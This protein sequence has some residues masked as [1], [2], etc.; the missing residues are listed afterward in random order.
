LLCLE[1]KKKNMYPKNHFAPRSQAS[2][3]A[4]DMRTRKGCPLRARAIVL[5]LIFGFVENTNFPSLSQQALQSPPPRR[6]FWTS[7][8][9]D[10]TRCDIATTLVGGLGQTL[11]NGGHK[12]GRSIY[13]E[14]LQG[15][16]VPSRALAPLIDAKQS[17]SD[18]ISESDVASFFE[19]YKTD[20]D[21]ARTDAF[22][23]AFPLS[24]CE[25]FLPFN[26]T[27]IYL[28]AHRYVLGR[29]HS[30]AQW[31]RLNK[32]LI[33]AAEFGHVVAAM[34]R[35]DAEYINYF[36]GLN[37]VVLSTNSFW[38]AGPPFT[39]FT[40]ERAEILVGPLQRHSVP[41][42]PNSSALLKADSL[43]RRHGSSTAVLSRCKSWRTTA[44]PSCFHMQS[45][46]TVLL[47]C[48]RLESQCLFRQ[49]SS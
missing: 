25:A 31:L 1:E 34:G 36:T 17:H 3:G 13:A 5:P 49:S 2:V 20:R 32:H 28:A 21:V 19:Y 16:E 12:R 15:V 10:G 38:Y 46:P 7:D 6:V 11:V 22:V 18:Y 33:E 39:N 14:C 48:I 23:C 40:G 30:E 24:F 29:C 41:F 8:L 37:P 4:N 42:R 47:K 44:R 9:H 43:S 35:F 45:F 26:R 27:I